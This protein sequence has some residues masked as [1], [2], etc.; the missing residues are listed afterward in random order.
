[1]GPVLGIAQPNLLEPLK[2]GENPKPGFGSTHFVPF[3]A[4][5]SYISGL[6]SIA[7][8][9]TPKKGAWTQVR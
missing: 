7:I 2:P 8:G 9:S 3:F 1:M 4:W 5:D 6:P